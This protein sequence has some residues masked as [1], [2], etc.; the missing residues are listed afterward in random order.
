LV[1]REGWRSH[2]APPSLLSIGAPV[3]FEEAT[4]RT[5]REAMAEG[6]LVR[7]Y[8]LEQVREVG[9]SISDRRRWRIGRDRD[10]A[11][12]GG[13]RATP[14]CPTPS[15]IFTTHPFPTRKSTAGR[16]CI[17]PSPL[18]HLL[19]QLRVGGPRPSPSGSSPS[20]PPS[21]SVTYLAVPSADELCL[22]GG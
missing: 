6:V 13:A 18:L 17:L 3:A 2:P 4:K 19:A 7:L 8:P 15:G 20:A 11:M 1:Q 9:P 21:S 12:T 5:M 14:R 22:R 16:L 10:V